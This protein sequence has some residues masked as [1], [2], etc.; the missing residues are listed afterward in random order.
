ML[1]D[2]LESVPVSMLWLAVSPKSQMKSVF[3]T[4]HVFVF[5]FHVTLV[6]VA[7]TSVTHHLLDDK[8]VLTCADLL[9]WLVV[10]YLFNC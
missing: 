8:L 3:I 7:V 5:R 6:T 10:P 2:S 4:D 9:C 1:A